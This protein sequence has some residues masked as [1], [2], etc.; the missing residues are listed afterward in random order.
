MKWA[1]GADHGGYAL[2]EHLKVK[3][4]ARGFEVRDFGCHGADSC[5]Y[6]DYANAVAKDP[7]A[8]SADGH[9]LIIEDLVQAVHR[10]REPAIPISTEGKPATADM[11]DPTVLPDGM[12]EREANFWSGQ[13]FS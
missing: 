13:P 2:K 6:T 7:M 8:V 11:I 12:S 3:L 4:Q 1:L 5:D 9:L 10:D